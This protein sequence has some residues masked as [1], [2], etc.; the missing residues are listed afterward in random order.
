MRTSVVIA[1]VAALAAAT[2]ASAYLNSPLTITRS[3]VAARQSC[4]APTMQLNPTDKKFRRA[5]ALRAEGDDKNDGPMGRYLFCFW[6]II[7]SR[8]LLQ[9]SVSCIL[10]GNCVVQHCCFDPPPSRGLPDRLS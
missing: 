1:F 9:H 4:T 6:Q 8:F 5:I 2:P 3:G 7:R 10:R